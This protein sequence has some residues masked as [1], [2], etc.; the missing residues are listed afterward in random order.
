MYLSKNHIVVPGISLQKYLFVAKFKTRLNSARKYFIKKSLMENQMHGTAGNCWV[1]REAERKVNIK[2]SIKYH[3]FY[4]NS[5]RFVLNTSCSARLSG[6]VHATLYVQVK[7][8][9]KSPLF[10]APSHP[11]CNR[12]SSFLTITIHKLKI[13]K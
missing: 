10:A 8:I 5:K 12:N 11:H 6:R 13:N 7:Q 3:M 4:H 1:L 9:K 2:Y